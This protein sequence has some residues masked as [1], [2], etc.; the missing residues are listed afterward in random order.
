MAMQAKIISFSFNPV[1][2][3]HVQK[4]KATFAGYRNSLR[5]VFLHVHLCQQLH[6]LLVLSRLFAKLQRALRTQDSIMKTLFR[7]R[8][9]QIIK[10]MRL[11]R[12]QSITIVSGHEDGNWHGVFAN[13]MYYFKSVEFGHLNVKKNKI[14]VLGLN[15]CDCRTP[16]AAFSSNFE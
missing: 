12:L 14:R 7:K 2:I 13:F 9:E 16:V 1:E 10:R 3:A 15:G 6:N 8:L 11:K 4:K 5:I